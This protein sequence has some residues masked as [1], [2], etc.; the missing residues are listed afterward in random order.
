MFGLTGDGCDDFKDKSRYIEL[1][2]AVGDTVWDKNGEP[3]K[4]VSIEWY[5]SKVFHLH[6]EHRTFSVGKRS[7]GKTVFL[8]KE[9]AEQKLKEKKND[10]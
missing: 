2:C 6:C 8:T 3:H 10:R 1:P 4:V 7:I 5:S 9:E